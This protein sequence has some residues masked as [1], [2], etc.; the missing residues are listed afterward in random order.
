MFS[1]LNSQAKNITFNTLRLKTTNSM[2]PRSLINMRP[3]IFF[4][5]YGVYLCKNRLKEF[6]TR[7]SLNIIDFFMV[8]T[9]IQELWLLI[10]VFKLQATV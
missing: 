9:R 10:P 8:N 4:K 2:L 3:V 1:L 6:Y 7:T 5:I